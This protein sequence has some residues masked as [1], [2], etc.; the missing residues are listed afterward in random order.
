MRGDQITNALSKKW[1]NRRLYHAAT[2]QSLSHLLFLF[3]FLFFLI[4]SEFCHTLKWNGLE[5]TCLP[6]PDPCDLVNWSTRGK[7]AFSVLH[8]LPFE[9]AQIRPLSQWCHPIISSSVIPFSCPQCFPASGSFSMSQ[10]FASGGQST[11]ASASALPMD[12][13][14]WFPLE[15]T[16]L[17]SLLSKESSPAPKFESIS[18]LVLNLLYGPILT[19]M[20]DYWKNHSFDYTDLCWQSDVSAFQ[21][22]EVYKQF[23][24]T[25]KEDKIGSLYDQIEINSGNFSDRKPEFLHVTSWKN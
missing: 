17:V 22:H 25:V 13:Q 7:P 19:S 2:A 15:L 16:I 4:C 21:Y 20:H 9:L 3:F 10:L 8:C 11:R 6:H 23:S 24:Y 1:F 18:S 12:I 14:G 5:F